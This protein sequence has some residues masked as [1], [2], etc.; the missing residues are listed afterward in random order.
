M[1]K[2]I[3]AGTVACTFFL[4]SCIIP[5]Q[6]H[7]TSAAPGA[8]FVVLGMEGTPLKANRVLV[9]TV[10]PDSPAA[11]AGLVPD[12]PIIAINGEL[13]VSAAQGIALL[14]DSVEAVLKLGYPGTEREVRLERKGLFG[15]A[16]KNEF[17]TETVN[18]AS[19][20]STE[21]LVTHSDFR[22][23]KETIK[24]TELAEGRESARQGA[25]VSLVMSGLCFLGAILLNP[26][27]ENSDEES[28]TSSPVTGIL[29]P[30]GVIFGTMGIFGG[31]AM[32]NAK[33]Y[34]ATYKVP[35]ER[36]AQSAIFDDQGYNLATGYDHYG[37]TR[38]G[39]YPDGARFDGRLVNGKREGYGS[40]ISPD[41]KFA[42][43]GVFQQDVL[44]GLA[45]EMDLTD[46]E[47]PRLRF[48]GCFRDS[49]RS[50]AGIE[51]DGSG[52][53]AFLV[54]S[55]EGKEEARIPYPQR[56]LKDSADLFFLGAG[57]AKG[58]AEGKGVALRLDGSESQEGTF[59]NGELIE[60]RKNLADGTVVQGTY[61]Q[62]SLVRGSIRRPDGSG[63]EGL[64]KHG[65]LQSPGKI[66]FA[67]GRVY[68]GSFDQENLR[69][70]EGTMTYPNG[71][72]YTGTLANQVPHGQ[73]KL[74]TGDGIVYA[75][76]FVNGNAQGEGKLIY[77]SGE[78]YEGTFSGG[79]PHGMGLYRSGTA[80]ERAE[81]VE[82]QR[83]DQVYLMRVERDRLAE[84]QQKRD[85]QRRV[86]EE[87]AERERREELRRQKEEQRLAE[88]RERDAQ[89]KKEALSLIGGLAA[90]GFASSQGISD[91]LAL[92]LGVATA[93]DIYDGET[94]NLD[95]L[96]TKTE[97][98]SARTSQSTLTRSPQSTQAPRM[99]VAPPVLPG[100]APA[101]PESG[102]TAAQ[103]PSS[104][105]AGSNSTTGTSQA[106]GLQK[107]AIRPKP[108]MRNGQP[109]SEVSIDIAAM[110]R[111]VGI[112][113]AQFFTAYKCTGGFESSSKIELKAN[114][115]GVGI[116]NNS[117]M[118]GKYSTPIEFEWGIQ[119]TKE[120]DI[121]ISERYGKK[122]MGLILV[123]TKP[124]DF[125][126]GAD[127]LTLYGDATGV[128][129][130]GDG[131]MF[132]AP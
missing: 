115:T 80:V 45:K 23:F 81:Y 7:L 82:G 118:G 26:T 101:A 92:D 126:G 70:G 19:G 62:D 47:Q 25:L 105:P 28:E 131:M 46:P 111:A 29:L 119:L 35:M 61:D 22:P 48:F 66:T 21:L 106:T 4:S 65:R 132:Q 76:S 16:L 33:T 88:E 112:P 79:V 103:T 1:F 130:F 124:T 2:K 9:A 64:W 34:P 14:S 18:N 17:P 107:P 83:V 52:K 37:I 85:E 98:E 94:E 84:D 87:T 71:A 40:M 74:K 38:D 41:G 12:E 73:G 75:G 91:D 31:L 129:F 5:N 123:Y 49:K 89:F 125:R 99:A 15:V 72:Q 8:E 13:L 78:S 96:R 36:F 93:K 32:S 43:A 24:P 120:G 30:F 6:V 10:V 57:F 127:L 114:G 121:A 27:D 60:G 122:G 42:V 116:I 67:D 109:Y 11:E 95:A 110:R 3:V 113:A 39:Q 50:G 56:P 117:G 102:G 100:L 108:L 86:A 104:A 63:A 97:A 68:S 55:R 20:I 51:F 53:P 69:S 77:A 90:T 59:S 44:N 128:A 58:L 54:V